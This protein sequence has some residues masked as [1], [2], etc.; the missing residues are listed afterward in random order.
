M[1]AEVMNG[2]MKPDVLPTQLK[3]AKNIIALGAGTTSEIM[4]TL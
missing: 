2:P 1:M 3:R 4:V